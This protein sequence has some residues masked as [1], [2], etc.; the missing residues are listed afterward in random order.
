MAR[1]S[2]DA[3][4][5]SIRYSLFDLPIEIIVHPCR[6]LNYDIVLKHQNSDGNPAYTLTLNVLTPTTCD[7]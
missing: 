6:L 3:I 2:E 4:K 1:R 5:F 7:N